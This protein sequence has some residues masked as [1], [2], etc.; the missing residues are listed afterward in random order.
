MLP[1]AQRG[2]ALKRAHGRSDQADAH[3]AHCAHK[4]SAVASTWGVMT[5]AQVTKRRFSV[6]HQAAGLEVCS[7]LLPGKD[8][9]DGR[10]GSQWQLH[11]LRAP[12][13]HLLLLAVPGLRDRK[14]ELLEDL[15]RS[16]HRM[17][18]SPPQCARH[19]ARRKGR[20]LKT[21]ANCRFRA[22]QLTA[23]LQTHGSTVTMA[24]SKVPPLLPQASTCTS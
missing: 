1:C 4:P 11:I 2:T 17:S 18:C 3:R 12:A 24:A 14:P 22:L 7:L 21:Q 9:Q 10:A 5:F 23:T 15:P 13:R 19:L 16:A 6:L 8:R 20:L